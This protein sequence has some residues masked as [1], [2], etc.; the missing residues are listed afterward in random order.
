MLFYF[1]DDAGVR[2]DNKG[3]MKSSVVTGPVAKYCADP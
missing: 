2:V 1:E 3:Q